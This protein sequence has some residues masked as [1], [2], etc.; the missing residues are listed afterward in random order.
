VGSHIRFA[1]D[2]PDRAAI[3]EIGAGTDLTIVGE[4]A[5]EPTPFPVPSPKE[6]A[7]ATAPT[8]QPAT[9]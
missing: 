1:W 6:P 2:E 7:P 5:L 4:P 3:I 9:K 8:T